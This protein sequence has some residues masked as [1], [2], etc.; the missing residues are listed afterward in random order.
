MAHDLLVADK[1]R[2]MI[3]RV[4]GAASFLSGQNVSLGGYEHLRPGIQLDESFP[5]S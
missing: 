1:Q 2:V 5:N 3:G 4:G